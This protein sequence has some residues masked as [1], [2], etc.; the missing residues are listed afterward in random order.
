MLIFV[1]MLVTGFTI[2]A[3]WFSSV[4]A[5]RLFFVAGRRFDLKIFRYALCLLVGT[6]A[7]VSVMA[8]AGERTELC[9]LCS[10]AS[11]FLL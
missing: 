1:G 10:R 4:S 2:N 5:L 9:R 7:R 11:E 8:L 6:V 3:V